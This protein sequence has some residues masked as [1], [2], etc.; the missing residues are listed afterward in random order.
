MLDFDSAKFSAPI[1]G[2]SLTTEP[3]SRAWE[4]PAKYPNPEDALKYYIN[5]ISDPEMMNRMADIL[6]SGL[7]ATSLTDS[8]ILSGVMKGLH[9]V[10]VGIIISRGLYIF[11]KEMGRMLDVDV[12]TGLEETDIPDQG[13]LRMATEQEVQEDSEE[14]KVLETVVEQSI[15]EIDVHGGIMARPTDKEEIPMQ[16]N[17]GEV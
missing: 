6:E 1:P 5:S 13:M 14:Q 16:I 9:S 4:K 15:D 11:I 3:K 17:E 7:P 2:M 10:D 8:I 12:V